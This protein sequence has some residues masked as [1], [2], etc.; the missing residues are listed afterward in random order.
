MTASSAPR[1]IIIPDDKL[2][3]YLLLPREENDKSKYLNSAGYNLTSWEVLAR[4]LRQLIQSNELLNAKTSAYGT[5]YEIRGALKGP[6]GRTLHVVT[7]WIKLD[8]TDSLR[9][10]TLFPDR[11][12]T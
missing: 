8:A 7:I 1:D 10:V 6:N 3:S 9:F 4:D 12:V 2:L 5:K 11:E